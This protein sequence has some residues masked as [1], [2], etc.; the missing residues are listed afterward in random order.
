MGGLT[1]CFWKS[2][3]ALFILRADSYI[4]VLDTDICFLLC[5]QFRFLMFKWRVLS[6]FL[7]LVKNFQLTKSY[8]IWRRYILVFRE[9]SMYYNDNGTVCDAIFRRFSSYLLSGM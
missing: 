7:Y 1:I 4:S 2:S 8:E 6:E 9:V 3:K 5:G